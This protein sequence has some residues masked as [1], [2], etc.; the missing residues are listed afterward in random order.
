MVPATQLQRAACLLLCALST[1]MLCV[2]AP[3]EPRGVLY[4][5]ESLRLTS[6]QIAINTKLARAGDVEAAHKLW[7]HY[8]FV[9]D[10]YEKADYWKAR[11]K[12]LRRKRNADSS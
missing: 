12:R 2:C 6:Q 4:G 5:N 10:N 7:L 11:Y 9:E 8:E 1:M 3:T